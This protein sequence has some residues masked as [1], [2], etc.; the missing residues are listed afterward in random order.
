[1]T[2]IVSF[3]EKSSEFGCSSCLVLSSR[4][5][6]V[7]TGTSLSGVIHRDFSKPTLLVWVQAENQYGSAKSEEVTIDREEISE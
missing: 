4:E 2:I 1:M 5:E 3:R 6:D 7:I